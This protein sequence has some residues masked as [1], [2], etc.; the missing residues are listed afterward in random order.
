ML[1]LLAFSV[2]SGEK[3][4]HSTKIATEVGLVSGLHLE[5]DELYVAS[6]RRSYVGRL[7]LDTNAKLDQ[8]LGA[9]EPIVPPYET[10]EGP[11]LHHMKWPGGIAIHD[12]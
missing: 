11:S 12:G 6:T 4:G 3:W 2:C 7:R 5:G 1:W 10:G 8:L 9:I